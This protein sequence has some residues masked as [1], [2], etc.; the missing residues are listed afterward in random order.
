MESFP[1]KEPGVELDRAR[2]P[3]DNSSRCDSMRRSLII[4]SFAG[5]Y[6]LFRRSYY[7]RYDI[8]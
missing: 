4:L 8:A 7:E 6:D 3:A 5:S 1:G 2:E